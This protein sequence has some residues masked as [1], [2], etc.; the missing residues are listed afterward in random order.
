MKKK[1]MLEL[2]LT[3]VFIIITYLVFSNKITVFDD[4]VY[5]AIFSIRN[6]FLDYFFKLIT[7]AGNATFIIC[8][9]I[10]LLLLLDKKSRNL[11]GINTIIT[12]LA[13]QVLK[14]I[15]RRKRP[16]HLRLIKQGGFSYP[17]GHAMI[18][19][20]IYGFLIYYA[21]KKIKNKTKRKITICLLTLL[22]IGIGISRIYVGVHYPSDI[23]AGYILSILIFIITED[24][25]K[26]HLGGKKNDKN[27]S[28]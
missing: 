26:N 19:V 5:N 18:G 15:F 27:D 16:T 6:N 7:K 21:S 2:F 8:L 14:N 11:L 25:Y 4:Y 20:A 1:Y 3:M 9:I 13:N 10:I 23:I 28:K 22:I 12:L 24:C 17:S